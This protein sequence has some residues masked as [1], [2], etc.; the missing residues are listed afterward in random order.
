MLPGVKQVLTKIGKFP[1]TFIQVVIW[2]GFQEVIDRIY[3]EGL[4]CILVICSSEYDGIIDPDL[5]ENLKTKSIHQ[6]DIHKNQ[7]RVGSMILKPGN[8]SFYRIKPLYY[9][10]IRIVSL[11]QEFQS[12]CRR[13]F[14]FNNKDYMRMDVIK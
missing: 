10:Y 4:Q 14:I 5:P 1:E 7:V 9:L 6:T 12:I 11:Q 3:L 8:A 13:F 2:D